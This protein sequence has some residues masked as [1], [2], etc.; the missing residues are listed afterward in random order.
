MANRWERGKLGPYTLP[1]DFTQGGIA[2]NGINNV[3]PK[4]EPFLVPA[5]TLVYFD[6]QTLIT[7]DSNV[8]QPS[9]QA[10]GRTAYSELFNVVGTQFGVGDGSTTFDI[11]DL[12]YTTAR[13]H[14]TAAASGI[15]QFQSGTMWQH[16]HTV[17]PLQGGGAANVDA[18][19]APQPITQQSAITNAT[20]GP[21]ISKAVTTV[22]E[23]SYTSQP[24]YGPT[25]SRYLNSLGIR[26]Y[27]T[28]NLYP[29]WTIKPGALPIG[30]IIPFVG[31]D[32]LTPY[33][34]YLLCNGQSV[35]SATYPL[36]AQNGIFT[37]PDL[38]GRFLS[39]FDGNQP[40]TFSPQIGAVHRHRYTATPGNGGVPFSPLIT[41]GTF[42]YGI[43]AGRGTFP[44]AYLFASKATGTASLGPG[45]ETRPTNMA[46]TFLMRV[47]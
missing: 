11:P 43:N 8:I 20:V 38:R 21:V 29:A 27:Q 34:G 33:S 36:A 9:G 17:D 7:E 14:G 31:N 24:T 22:S 37:V 26:A 42:R 13:S 44:T 41:T 19:T 16:D 5:G 10:L 1:Q 18:L 30:S 35:D 2:L 15:G 3:T 23:G 47:G 40:R 6:S 39:A 28:Y 32:D 45:N 12:H 25:E 4:E 46:V